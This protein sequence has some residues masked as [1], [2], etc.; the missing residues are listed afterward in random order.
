MHISRSLTS[1]LRNCSSM[2]SF[3]QRPHHVDAL[4]LGGEPPRL[5]KVLENRH[6]A[7][8]DD[9]RMRWDQSVIACPA[10]VD[11]GRNSLSKA[12]HAKKDGARE[13]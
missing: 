6:P 13:S 2:E 5:W 11:W 7:D 1:D 4:L 10:L 9:A 3:A 12:R 8:A